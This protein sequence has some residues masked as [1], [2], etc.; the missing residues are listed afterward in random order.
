MGGKLRRA[1][2]DKMFF[3][4]QNIFIRLYQNFLTCLFQKIFIRLCQTFSSVYILPSK[5]FSSVYI[6]Q[7]KTF[8][9]VFSCRC[10][11]DASLLCS[12]LTAWKNGAMQ[13]AGSITGDYFRKLVFN[14]YRSPLF[15]IIS[16]F[17]PSYKFPLT[18]FSFQI[19]KSRCFH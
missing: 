14:C 16:S 17:I 6:L 19:K 2:A 18:K 10:Q 3:F 12:G 8:Q 1:A 11:K 4:S 9:S 5:T 7:S 15:C 13:T